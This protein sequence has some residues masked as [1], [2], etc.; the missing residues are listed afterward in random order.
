M[1]SVL[2]K[3]ESKTWYINLPNLF[4]LS[5]MFYSITFYE[6]YKSY[7]SPSSAFIVLFL[8]YQKMTIFYGNVYFV[9][10]LN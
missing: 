2:N 4:V 10:C 8:Q 3:K 6:L 1:S 7:S 9:L 5:Q